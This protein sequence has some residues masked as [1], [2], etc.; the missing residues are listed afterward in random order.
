MT[1]LA[2][3]VVLFVAGL[4]LFGLMALE[5]V[6]IIGADRSVTGHLAEA[7]EISKRI[8]SNTRDVPL[9]SQRIQATQVIALW[10]RVPTA[11]SFTGWDFYPNYSQSRR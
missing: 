10:E 4:A 5:G 3:R 1:P 8:E 7:E 9:Q 11:D 6:L 2:D